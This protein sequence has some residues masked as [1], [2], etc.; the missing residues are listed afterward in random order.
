MIISPPALELEITMSFIFA[1]VGYKSNWS[2]PSPP[3]IIMFVGTSGSFIP[4]VY[5]PLPS[6]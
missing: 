4:S 5:G 1:Y 2:N 6:G 3:G